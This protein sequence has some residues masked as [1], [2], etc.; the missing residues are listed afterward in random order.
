V[1]LSYWGKP[2][3]EGK[4]PSL[5]FGGNGWPGRHSYDQARGSVI[6]VAGGICEG[7]GGSSGPSEAARKTVVKQAGQVDEAVV[8]RRRGI[9]IGEGRRRKSLRAHRVG[10]Q[11]KIG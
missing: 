3:K 10:K 9:A 8:R 11:R 7:L 6:A 5:K 2:F 1:I 4:N